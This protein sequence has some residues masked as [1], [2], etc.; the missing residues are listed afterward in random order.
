MDNRFGMKEFVLAVLIIVAI[1]SIWISAV[2]SSRNWDRMDGLMAAMEKQQNAISSYDKTVRDL[3][4]ENNALKGGVE[5]LIEVLQENAAQG[6]SGVSLGENPGISLDA[7]ADALPNGFEQRRLANHSNP[8]YAEGDWYVTAVNSVIPK[9]TPY[10]PGD[11]VGSY[12][13]WQVLETLAKRDWDDIEVWRPCLA[14]SWEVSDDGM[15]ITFQLRKDVR[16][17]G[18]E[19][20]TSADVVFT[21][22]WV[23]N[24][25]IAA[26]RARTALDRIESVVANGPYEVVFTLKDT[27]FLGFET[28]AQM[29]ILSEEYYSQFTPDEFNTLPGLLYGSGPYRLQED[30]TQWRPGTDA[31]VLVRNE[32]YWSV[33]PAL[34]RMVFK[35]FTTRPALVTA[36]RNGEFDNLRVQPDEYLN[37]RDDENLRE[38][39]RW[40][41]YS[42]VNGGYRYLG[43]NTAKPLFADRRV[44]QALTMLTNRQQM[45]ERLMNGTA[46]VANGPF[47]PLG[48]QDDPNIEPWPYDPERALALLKEAGWEDRDGDDVLENEAGEQFRFEITYPAVSESYRMMSVAIQ[49]TMNEAGIVVELNGQ[50]WNSM[51]EKMDARDFDA[52][53]L[54]WG[55]GG[56]EGDVYQMFHSDSIADGGD[57][58]GSFRSDELDAALEAARFELDKEKRYQLWHEVHRILHEEQPYTFLF[59]SRNIRLVD[60]R[61]R[62]AEETTLYD[63]VNWDEFYV[64]GNEQL[65]RQ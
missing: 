59:N 8:D 17:S 18:G 19:P 64:P 53:T 63:F 5:R 7:A 39:R 6:N 52:I 15:T 33:K 2:G 22:N 50:E 46:R 54:G 43:W 58:Y 38:G 45:T 20:L 49:Q 57:N 23:M 14:E 42:I 31:T 36:F 24:P 56:P 30:P 26:P 9:L 25:D 62:N 35:I 51:L 4:E 11:T 47:H 3:R 32:N 12:I 41:E 34:S 55:A 37:F 13:Q 29:E 21:Y 28:C 1:V 44:R 40:M 16:F 10:I 65:P 27:Y 61:F 48:N 60:D